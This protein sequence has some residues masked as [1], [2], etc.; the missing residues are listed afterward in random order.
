MTW[1]LAA[2]SWWPTAQAGSGPVDGRL[3]LGHRQGR[4]VAEGGP[5]EELGGVAQGG[6]DLLG[7]LLTGDLH[8]DLVLALAGHGG[9]AGAG[10]D[11]VVQDGHDGVELGLVDRAC[12]SGRPRPV[13]RRGRGRAWATIRRPGWR[14][15]AIDRDGDHREQADPQRAFVLH[16]RSGDRRVR[17][18]HRLSS[19]LGLAPPW[20]AGWSSVAV[21]PLIGASRPRRPRRRPRRPTGSSASAVVLVVLARS[22]HRRRTVVICR[23]P[24]A[25]APRACGSRT[26]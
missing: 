17:Q 7:V 19:P 15:R 8:R 10:V 3:A 24:A 4:G 18:G 11:P 21:A 20:P 2:V 6:Q 14:S 12:G 25:P 16:G 9:P 26:A 22:R 1:R 5:E 13:R 23:P